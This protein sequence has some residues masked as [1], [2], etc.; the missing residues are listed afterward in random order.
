MNAIG[1]Y[2]IG[3]YNTNSPIINTNQPS[4]N[5]PTPPIGSAYIYNNSDVGITTQGLIPIYDG[6]NQSETTVSENI[7]QTNLGITI[8]NLQ[9]NSDVSTNATTSLNNFIVNVS[10]VLSS[11]FNINVNP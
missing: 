3:A 11:A 6:V 9:V 1:F 8:S 5:P 4:S 7:R 2:N 10:Q